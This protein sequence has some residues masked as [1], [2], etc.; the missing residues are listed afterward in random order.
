MEK[1]EEG[2]GLGDLQDKGGSDIIMALQLFESA[3]SFVYN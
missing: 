1:Q 2:G 3:V